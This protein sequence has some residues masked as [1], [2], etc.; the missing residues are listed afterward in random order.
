MGGDQPRP[1][2]DPHLGGAELDPHRP[3]D[4]LRRHRVQTLPDGDPGMP[5]DPGGQGQP[6]RERLAGQRPQRR[7]LQLPV[8]A[9]GLDPVGD[10]AVLV[11]GVGGGQQLV[12]LCDRVD[13]GHRDAVGAAEPAALTLHPA[14]LM[15]AVDAGLAVEGVET[16]VGTERHPPV[17]L[18]PV[19]A[20]QHPRHRRL[21]VVVADVPPR[22]PTQPVE[23][24]DMAFQERL[25][26]LGCRTPDAPTGPRPTA[27]T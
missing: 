27:G 25:L 13:F 15:R 1:V 20:G 10:P 21:Q 18:E 4:Q 17:G 8:V 24:V 16:V 12:E 22:H 14:L 11:L 9:D 23:R 3:A 2:E 26:R 5:I 7:P 19:A 6:G